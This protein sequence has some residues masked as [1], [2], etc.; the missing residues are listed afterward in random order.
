MNGGLKPFTQPTHRYQ[1][2]ATTTTQTCAVNATATIDF[3]V[4]T[5]NGLTGGELIYKNWEMGDYIKMDVIHPV[6]KD[7]IQPYVVKRFLGAD[8]RE[9]LDLRPL[10]AVVPVGLQIRT[11]YTAVNAGTAREFA[12]NFDLFEEL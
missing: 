11:T 5:A 2:N 4:G 3:S 1:G 6:T 9:T 7:V 10:L 12:I 8:G